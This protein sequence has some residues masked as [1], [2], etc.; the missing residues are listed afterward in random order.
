MCS[1]FVDEG[2]KRKCYFKSGVWHDELIMA[3]STK[4]RGRPECMSA[5][6]SAG[7]GRRLVRAAEEEQRSRTAFALALRACGLS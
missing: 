1:G 7:L 6:F 3:V 2:R 4:R 5:Y